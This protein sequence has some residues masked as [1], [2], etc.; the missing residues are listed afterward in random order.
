MAA[1]LAYQASAGCGK[2]V[3]RETTDYLED[4]L[5]EDAVKS[6]TGP[7]ATGNAD[8]SAKPSQ[9]K[10]KAPDSE[11]QIAKKNIPPIDLAGKWRVT[12]DKDLLESKMEKALDLILIQSGDRLQGY[13]TLDE[14]GSDIPATATG[15]ISKDGISLDVK[16]TKQKRDYRLDLA[17]INST[18]EGSY[19]LYEEE[20][21]AAKGNAT[22]RRS[23]PGA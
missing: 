7:N 9:S 19:E 5:F 12:L 23:G 15:S 10:E 3:I 20:N 21:L 17:Q 6:S 8:S 1:M 14:R 16:L 4:P 22:A 18:L 11:V 13:G 2:W